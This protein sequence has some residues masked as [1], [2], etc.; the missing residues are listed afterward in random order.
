MNSA[1]LHLYTEIDIPISEEK[2]NKKDK[3]KKIQNPTT[4][5]FPRVIWGRAPPPAISPCLG[6][7]LG[8]RGPKP[9]VRALHGSGISAPFGV[10]LGCHLSIHLSIC[11]YSVCYERVGYPLFF[12]GAAS[13][14][15]I[16]F[17]L[18]G[19]HLFIYLLTCYKIVIYPVCIIRV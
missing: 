12:I 9:F 17:V 2:E 18:L 8:S 15:G 11:L 4:F 3:E 19:C 10:L 1:E 6:H 13:V 5:F 16:L 14:Y 7:P